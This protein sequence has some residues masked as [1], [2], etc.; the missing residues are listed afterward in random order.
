MSAATQSLVDD[1]APLLARDPHD[2]PDGALLEDTET[3]LK[4]RRQLDGLIAAQLQVVDARDLTTAYYAMGTRNWLIAD[5]LLSKPDADARLR[6]ARSSVTRP[7]IL[8]ALRCGEIG[9]DHA[10]LIVNFL[11]GLPGRE[12]RDEAE[13]LLLDAAKETDPTTMTRGLRQLADRLSLHETAE[14]RAVRRHEGRYLHF[15]DTFSGMVHL[16]CMLDAPSATILRTALKPLALPAGEI[17]ERSPGQRDADALLELARMTMN[18]G[19]LPDT[20]GEPTQVHV[21]TDIDELTRDLKLGD[22]YTATLDGVPIT[23]DTVR[24]LACDAG[25]IPVVMRGPSEVLDLGRST[26]TWSRA[27]RKAAKI[28]A[29]GH[30]ESPRCQADVSRCDLHHEDHWSNFGRTDLDNGIYLCPYHHWLTHHTSWTIT[31]NKTSGQVEVRR[32]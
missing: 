15:F 27:Q 16:D 6:V 7:Q 18:R 30:C 24:M 8:D 3:L 23:P 11:P 12:Q 26:R 14:E 9:L 20:A 25:I 31:R 22:G 32:T 2:L 4:L 5:Q 1:L 19:E 10:K 29:R 28:R 21:L 17:D 13:K